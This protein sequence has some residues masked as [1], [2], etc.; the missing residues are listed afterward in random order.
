MLGF[1]H[2]VSEE[3][4]YNR[5]KQ[6]L[7]L[8]SNPVAYRGSFIHSR[9]HCPPPETERSGISPNSHFWN[10]NKAGWAE[11]KTRADTDK[12]NAFGSM[13]HTRLPNRGQG[14]WNRSSQN[15]CLSTYWLLR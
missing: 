13:N 5:G 6:I 15:I 7:E 14:G 12:I 4:S 1:E 10:V 8:Q 2:R 3:H 9:W 11:L